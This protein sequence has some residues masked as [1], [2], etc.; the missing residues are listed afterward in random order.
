MHTPL[1]AG[2]M[3]ESLASDHIFKMG[4]LAESQFFEGG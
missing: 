4:A 3:G 1:S 2:G